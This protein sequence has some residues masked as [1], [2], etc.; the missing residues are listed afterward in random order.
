M[1]LL[2]LSWLMISQGV[3]RAGWSGRKVRKKNVRCKSVKF[4]WELHKK[5]RKPSFFTCSGKRLGLSRLVSIWNIVRF[6][7]IM[8][9]R[10]MVVSELIGLDKFEDF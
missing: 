6:S 10:E 8:S 1:S 4:A 2:V 5:S 7:S 3:Q 9:K